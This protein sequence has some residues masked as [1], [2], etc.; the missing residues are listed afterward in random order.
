[1]QKDNVKTWQKNVSSIT[2]QFLTLFNCSMLYGGGHPNTAKNAAIFAD[3]INSCMDDDQTRREMITVI[4]HNGSMVIEDSPVDK[5]L[6]TGKLLSHFEKLAVTSVSLERGL[7]AES[8][9]RLMEAAGDGDIDSLERC[10][11]ALSDIARGAASIPNIRIN[12]VQYGKIS[13]D[14][15]VVKAADVEAMGADLYEAIEVQ[16]A[17]GRMMRSAAVIN[18]E[19]SDLTAH[20]IVKLVRDEY[21]S[22]KTPINRLAHTIRRMLPNNAELMNVLPQMK[23]MLL[24]DGMSLG[25]YLELVRALGL[26]VE[27]ESLSDSLKEAED[28][29]APELFILLPMVGS[30][31]TDTVKERIVKTSSDG[32]FERAGQ[33]ASIEVKVSATVPG[34][35]TKD[36]KSYLKVAKNNHSS[37]KNL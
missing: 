17:A 15:A 35:D 2:R 11:A 9:S 25:G 37:N 6:N 34:E 18:K 27:N 10:K 3:L 14:E 36:L 23:E 4:F 28:T 22:G 21:G 30:E 24:A 33:K 8:V 19:I 12:Y 31:G 13:A 16:K 26:K 5:S 1:M 29:A 32:K 20:A 7:R